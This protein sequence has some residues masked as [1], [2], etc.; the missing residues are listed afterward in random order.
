ME[1]NNIELL[2]Q[3]VDKVIEEGQEEIQ[4]AMSDIEF[5]QND[6]QEL[7][8]INSFLI[9]IYLPFQNLTLELLQVQVI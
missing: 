5:F 8:T 4:E 7:A 9:V 6:I 1:E 3:E 2:E